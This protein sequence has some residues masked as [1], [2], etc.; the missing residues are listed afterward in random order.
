LLYN[1]EC[2]RMGFIF[3]L[4]G[5]SDRLQHSRNGNWYGMKSLCGVVSWIFLAQL[6][7]YQTPVFLSVG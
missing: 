6:Q 4:A 1:L 3:G 7:D 5:C 2:G